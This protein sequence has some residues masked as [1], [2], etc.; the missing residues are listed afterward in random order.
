MASC[1]NCQVYDHTDIFDMPTPDPD[2]PVC[3]GFGAQ[4][5]QEQPVLPEWQPD[6]PI[7]LNEDK[8]QLFAVQLCL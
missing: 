2:C 1:T 5:E 8:T 3:F 6:I 4:D 7:I